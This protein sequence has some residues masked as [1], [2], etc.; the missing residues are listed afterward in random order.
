MFLDY[1]RRLLIVLLLALCV[2]VMFLTGKE[3]KAMGQDTEDK[4]IFPV[5]GVI[6]DLYGTRS[7]THKG[8]DIGGEAGSAVY[9][10]R[11]GIV[12]KS[13]YS[14]SYGNVVFISHDNGYETVYAHLNDRSVSEN[15]RVTQGDT[16]GSLG[17]TGRSTGAHLH[18]E[19]HEGVWTLDKEN[20]IDPFEVFGNGEIGQLVFAKV[21]DPYQTFEASVKLD[22]APKQKEADKRNAIEHEIIHIVKENETLWGIS[23][24]YGLTVDQVK[25][26]NGIDADNDVILPLQELRIELES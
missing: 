23:Q 21:Q 8:M 1:A 7:G 15:D 26:W 25:G 5:D 20:A 17:N 11:G 24:L 12:S 16:I 2:S 3:A 4:W 22:H 14:E 6:T 13:Y 19:I 9:A 18:F 10:A